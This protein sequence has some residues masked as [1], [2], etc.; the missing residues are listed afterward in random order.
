MALSEV[1]LSPILSENAT[2]LLLA[3]A[4]DLAIGDPEYRLHPV[5]LIG[6]ALQ[7]LEAALRRIGADGYVGGVLLFLLLSTLA[8]GVSAGVYSR[9]DHIHA[10]P[11]RPRVARAAIARRCARS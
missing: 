3:V 8:V 10:G 5:R 4:L 2:V 1:A 7:A 9:A 11:A 6:A